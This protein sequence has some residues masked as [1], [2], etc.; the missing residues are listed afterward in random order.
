[1][2]EFTTDRSQPRMRIKRN[3][4]SPHHGRRAFTPRRHVIKYCHRSRVS[5]FEN[6]IFLYMSTTRMAIGHITTCISKTV[7]PYFLSLNA[8][9]RQ[10]VNDN[11]VQECFLMIS[12]FT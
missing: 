10:N 8:S 7:F 2:F 1:M 11:G 12:R 3:I 5:K 9:N 6:D 4:V